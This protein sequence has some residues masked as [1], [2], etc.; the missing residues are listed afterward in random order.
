MRLWG[1][2]SSAPVLL[3]FLW[4][5]TAQ[6]QARQR[7]LP[8]SPAERAALEKKLDPAL[9]P[10]GARHRN[11]DPRQ[12]FKLVGPHGTE[13]TVAPVVF[14]MPDGSPVW[15]SCGVYIVPVQGAAYFLDFSSVDPGLDIPVLCWRVVS[16]RLER[17]EGEPSDIVLVGSDSLTSRHSWNQDYILHRGKDGIYDLS[18]DFKDIP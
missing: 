4:V 8:P 12:I 18:A 17:R 14:V 7:L 1:I 6:A 13:L 9:M 10:A 15:H 2:S 11:I 16:V 3:A 5:V